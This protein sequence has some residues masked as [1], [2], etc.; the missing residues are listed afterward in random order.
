VT[1]PKGKSWGSRC[2]IFQG[3]RR[4][5][6]PKRRVQKTK[7]GGMMARSRIAYLRQEN[8]TV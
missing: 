1:T 8:S 7:R 6:A 2:L 4:N 3:F 5:D